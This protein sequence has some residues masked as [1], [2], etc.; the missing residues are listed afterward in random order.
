MSEA[1]AAKMKERINDVMGIDEASITVDD[2]E[3]RA[4]LLSLVIGL[5][6]GLCVVGF[7][8]LQDFVREVA[9]DDWLPF[10]GTNKADIL[11]LFGD[12][13]TIHS[14]GAAW[15]IAVFPI[16]GAIFVGIVRYLEKNDFGPP[17]KVLNKDVT[18]SREIVPKKIGLKTVSSAITLGS[19]NSLGPEGPV[20]E[21]GGNIGLLVG[22]QVG[23][24]GDDLRSFLAAG[25]AAG[26]AAG[27]NAPISAIFFALEVVLQNTTEK[28]ALTVTLLSAVIAGLVKDVTLGLAPKFTVPQADLHGITEVPF[29]MLVGAFCGVAAYAFD[30]SNQTSMK[31]FSNSSIPNYLRPLVGSAFGIA[32]AM[33]FPQV[34][35]LGY[36]GVDNLL[37]T[38]PSEVTATALASIA[39]IAPAKI[40]VTS[41]ALGSGLVGGVFAP[42]LFIGALVGTGVGDVLQLSGLGTLTSEGL[43]LVAGPSTYTLIGMASMLAALVKAPLT[44]ILLVFEITRDY[45]T[46]LPVMAGV[47]MS[48]YV[49][50][51]ITKYFK[52]SSVKSKGFMSGACSIE[53]LAIT[54][55]EQAMYNDIVV[56]AGSTRILDAAGIV[57]KAQADQGNLSC[58]GVVLTDEGGMP[59]AGATVGQIMDA[60]DLVQEQL[61]AAFTAFDTDG[62]GS[63]DSGE[64]YE[65]LTDIGIKVSREQVTKLMKEITD[66][67]EITF[68]QFVKNSSLLGVDVGG[69][70]MNDIFQSAGLIETRSQPYVGR[71]ESLAVAAKKLQVTDSGVV[72]VVESTAAPVPKA[73]GIVVRTSVEEACKIARLEMSIDSM[74]M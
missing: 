62:S 67:E 69:R 31:F 35:F 41:A 43:D 4:L 9:F 14:V 56:V 48:T 68:K 29:F 64:V 40:L 1:I 27:F 70:T 39:V 11:E 57:A 44:S 10:L 42:S 58:R 52:P 38:V 32:V 51:Q 22:R 25:S 37:H 53:A 2:D 28:G 16:F 20:V 46:V 65:L 73:V 8:L 15:Q 18:M 63:I 23:Y 61:Q 59:V 33:F 34:L 5:S 36:K 54:F 30:R 50:G 19:A 45:D 49:D 60:V 6:T 74:T 12:V 21:L 17:I 47:G 7:E 3:T 55:T 13:S 24:R 66:E 26:L 72:V 71:K